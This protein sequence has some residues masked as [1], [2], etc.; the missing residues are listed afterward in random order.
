VEKYPTSVT[1]NLLHGR[2][3]HSAPAYFT[4]L[5]FLRERERLEKF[6]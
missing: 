3:K 6:L 2:K 1:S 4:L 5:S